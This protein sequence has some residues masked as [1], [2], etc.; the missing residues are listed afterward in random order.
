[1]T[2]LHLVRRLLCFSAL[3]MIGAIAISVMTHDAWLLVGHVLGAASAV[4]AAIAV[5]A[6]VVVGLRRIAADLPPRPTEVHVIAPFERGLTGLAQPPDT[7]P[8]SAP[9]ADWSPD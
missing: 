2:F 6:F 9:D 3:T 7:E 4:V 1:M 8:P 5:L